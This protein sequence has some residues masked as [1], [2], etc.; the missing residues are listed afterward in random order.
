VP[1]EHILRA[2]QA[3]AEGEITKTTQAASEEAAQLIAEAEAEAKTIRARHR[4][5]VEPMLL[6]EAASVQNKAKIGALR[7]AANAREQLLVEAFTRAQDCLADLR[8]SN[9]YPGIFR[10]LA[11]EAVEGLGKDVVVR[12]DAR[13]LALARTT[14]ADLGVKAEIQEQPMPL[15]GLQVMTRDGRI[16]IVNTLASRLERARSVLRGPV[17]GILASQPTSPSTPSPEKRGSKPSPSLKRE[18]ARG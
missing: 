11:R 17:A 2:M 7:A 13:D 15:G 6:A 12:V 14:F 16:A 1:L 4:A 18:G 8:T 3:Q 9:K 5:R 10:Q